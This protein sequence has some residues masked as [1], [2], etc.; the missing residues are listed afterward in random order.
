MPN[1]INLNFDF[2]NDG[3]KP[4][5]RVKTLTVGVLSDIG[6][7]FTSPIAMNWGNLD[8]FIE[9]HIFELSLDLNGQ[10]ID[11]PLEELDSFHPDEIYKKCS[12]FA[13]LR[14]LKKR[15]KDP[16]T[17]SAAAAELG[18]VEAPVKQETAES[19]S[20]TLLE[21]LLGGKVEQVGESPSQVKSQSESFIGSI[22]APYVI[23]SENPQLE[24]YLQMVEMTMVGTMKDILH[25]PK[26]QRAESFWRSLDMLLK[27]VEDEVAVSVYLIQADTESIRSG[28]TE[29]MLLDSHPDSWDVLIGDFSIEESDEDL[30]LLK[31]ANE[32]ASKVGARFVTSLQVSSSLLDKSEDKIEFFEDVKKLSAVELYGPNFLLR[33]P[34]GESTDEIDSFLFE[35]WDNNFEHGDYLWAKGAFA[36]GI[37]AI[38]KFQ[39]GGRS[40]SVLNDLVVHVVN[41][42]ATPSAEMWLSDRQIEKLQ[43]LGIFPLVSIRGRDSI[44]VFKGFKG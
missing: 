38:D 12:V 9:E 29:S 14:N 6:P 23:E 41:S 33:Y 35:E 32:L 3:K 25:H 36:A 40:G 1:G 4:E 31:S 37:I 13:T 2:N 19:S 21:G 5:K 34:Y 42:Q 43:N 18:S 15:L 22:V 28:S 20:D 16:A 30:V 24:V 10:Q 8:S 39:S 26:F 17:F 11:I 7:K 44:E 27:R